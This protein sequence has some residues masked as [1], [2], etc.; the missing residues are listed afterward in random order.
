MFLK[1]F[2]LDEIFLHTQY[3]N[4]YF[5]ACTHLCCS[6]FKDRAALVDSLSSISHLIP[7]V[8]YFFQLFSSFFEVLISGF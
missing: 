6:I 7:F 2:L 5:R 1:G 4:L 8:K 3:L